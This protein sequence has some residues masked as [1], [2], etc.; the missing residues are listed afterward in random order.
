MDKEKQILIYMAIGILAFCALYFILVTFLPMPETGK[1]YA[2]IILGALIGSGFT[3]LISFYYGSSKS[4]QDKGEQLNLMEN[5]RQTASDK[6][7]AVVAAAEAK[8]AS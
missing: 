8:E 6:A 2:D 5:K 4:S 3:A 7:V 1:R